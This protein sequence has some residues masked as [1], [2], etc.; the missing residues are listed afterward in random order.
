MTLSELLKNNR[1]LQKIFETVVNAE[2]ASMVRLKRKQIARLSD[3]S[4]T[5]I[6]T[7]AIVVDSLIKILGR[8]YNWNGCTKELKRTLSQIVMHRVVDTCKQQK[9]VS[10]LENHLS[11]TAN[12]QPLLATDEEQLVTL[13]HAVDRLAVHDPEQAHAFI[14][15]TF[16]NTSIEQI[17]D[18]LG[19][20]ARKT[21]LL[22]KKAKLWLAKK[23]GD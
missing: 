17:S 21:D 23:L 1:D 14:L 16:Q 19:C 5:S 6:A 18:I 9:Q 13:A 4:T 22:L 3:C 15:Q 10:D 7:S 12:S 8:H 11:E 2:L 20:S